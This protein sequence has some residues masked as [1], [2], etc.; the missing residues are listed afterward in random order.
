[1]T[2][3]GGKNVLQCSRIKMVLDNSLKDSEILVR[4]RSSNGLCDIRSNSA[5]ILNAY[6]SAKT[7]YHM[8]SEA[9][10]RH[11]VTDNQLTMLILKPSDLLAVVVVAVASRP[12][13]APLVLLLAVLLANDSEPPVME[14]LVPVE[15]EAE[16]V[17]EAKVEVAIPRQ[18]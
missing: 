7:H 10:M 15:R 4:G 2:R 11:V 13:S 5:T 9:I 17:F 3:V 16:P 18:M 12:V 1:M 6:V 14:L 8:T